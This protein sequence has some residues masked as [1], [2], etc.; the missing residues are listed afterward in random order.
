MKEHGSLKQFLD[1]Q[2]QKYN[3]PEFIPQDPISIPRRF[4]KLQDIEI[5]GFWIAMLSWGQRKTIINKGDELMTIMDNAPYEFVMGCSDSDLKRLSRFK[6]RTFNST[7]SLYFVD[8]FKRFYQQQSSLENAFLTDQGAFADVRASISSFHQ[9]FFNVDYAPQ[10]TRKHVA[11]PDRNSACK[12]INMFLRWMVR[13]DHQGVDFGLW[14]V[15]RP[16][17]LICPCDVHV[18]RTARQ[19]GLVTR[20]QSDWKM[21]VELTTNLRLLDPDDPVKYDFALFGLSNNSLS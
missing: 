5:S 4:S 14:E 9:Q 12:R 11:T 15:L 2:C 8:F 10:R 16:R 1:Q 7:D 18:E 21:A 19:L 6:H 17:D 3:T 13:K 20:K